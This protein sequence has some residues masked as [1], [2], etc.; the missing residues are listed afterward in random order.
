MR[1]LSPVGLASASIAVGA[2]TPTP[3]DS[4]PAILWSTL[5]G[6]M[7][8][9]NGSSWSQ[10]TYPS[11]TFASLPAA[12]AT[13]TIFNVTDIGTGALMRFNGILWVPY[14]GGW[15]SL[16]NSG[17]TMILANFT[18]TFGNNGALT[19]PST[20]GSD[21]G[22]GSSYI[23]YPANSIY[24]GSPAGFYWTTITSTTAAT[25]YN[26]YYSG[27]GLPIYP[28]T[29]VSFSGTTGA[30][31]VAGVG[32]ATTIMSVTIPASFLG[33]NGKIRS[34]ITGTQVAGGTGALALQYG[35]NSVNSYSVTEAINAVSEFGNRQW[36]SSQLVMNN[37]AASPYSLSATPSFT[38][39]NSANSQ[40]L[41]L[42]AT[43]PAS[44]MHVL[45]GW[46]VEALPG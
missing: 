5:Y 32:T 43:Q 40:T 34:T 39:T 38:T 17:C 23:Y 29:P 10:A 19:I 31:S 4:L 33:Y 25:I 22:T 14:S 42:V 37:T 28:V 44:T 45:W 46:H 16:Q 20:M 2:T 18:M 3:S 11:S 36:L 12:P 24:S 6:C 41:N 9:W 35:G 7:M 27:L 26:N 13:G 21:L 30:G 8:V 15:I 1:A